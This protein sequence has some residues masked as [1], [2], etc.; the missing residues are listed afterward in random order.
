M[1]AK[2]QLVIRLKKNHIFAHFEFFDPMVCTIKSSILEAYTMIRCH[3][4]YFWNITQK[5]FAQLS[6]PLL[7]KEHLIDCLYHFEN[8]QWQRTLD[9]K[10]Q[11]LQDRLRAMNNHHFL[12]KVVLIILPHFFTTYLKPKFSKIILTIHRTK[13]RSYL[14]NNR[15]VIDVSTITT[16][17]DITF[18][19]VYFG[20]KLCD[21][22]M[23]SRAPLTAT[24][25]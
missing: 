9:F 16:E 13:N 23:I 4:Q 15:Y 14:A 25:D 6:R 21:I 17:P 2:K 20:V 18:L 10:V 1:P 24:L 22:L 19:F 7:H 5:D 12:K 8:M 11:K 3:K